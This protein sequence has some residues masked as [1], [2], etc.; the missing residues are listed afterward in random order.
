MSVLV[1][2]QVPGGT[3]ENDQAMMEA[4]RLKDPPPA[5]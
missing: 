5:I 3:L 1:L 4:L 2:A